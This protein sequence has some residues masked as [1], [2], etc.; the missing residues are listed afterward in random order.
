VQPSRTKEEFRKLASDF[1]LRWSFL[2]NAVSKVMTLNCA[3]SFGKQDLS[4]SHLTC[5]SVS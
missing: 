1:Q 3:D 4:D 2:L 5:P